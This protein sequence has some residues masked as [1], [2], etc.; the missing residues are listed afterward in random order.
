MREALGS[1]FTDG[2]LNLDGILFLDQGHRV[3]GGSRRSNL[4]ILTPE[5]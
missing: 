2:E 5:A 1:L 3:A 4:G